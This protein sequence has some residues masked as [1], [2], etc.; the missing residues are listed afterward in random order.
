MEQTSYSGRYFRTSFGDIKSS[1]GWFGKICLLGL[2][3]LIPVFGQMTV[4]GYAYEW[5]H[6][7]A[8][9]M[10]SPMP[11]KIYGRPGS[12]MLRW[13]WFVLV[14]GIV[15]S[16]A[17]GIVMSIGGSLSS[18]G[19]ETGF[20]TATGRYMMVSPGNIALGG[21][22]WV[23]S[24]IGLVLTVFAMLMAWAGTMRMTVYD[25]LG[26]GFQ[27]GKLW[28]MVRQ[29]FGG[30]MRIFGMALLFGIIG[31]VVI[32][33]IMVIAVM[34]ILGATIAP[35]IF[36]IENGGYYTDSALIG[37]ILTLV[38][39]MLPLILVVSY[40]GLVYNAFI[41]LLVARALGYWMRQFD[42]A[43]WGTQ[44]DPLPSAPAPG[45]TPVHPEP[46]QASAGEPVTPVEPM[47]EPVDM[48][49]PPAPV[50]E[51]VEVDQAPA[52]V[53]PVEAEPSAPLALDDVVVVE[54]ALDPPVEPPADSSTAGEATVAPEGPETEAES[55][56]APESETK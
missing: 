38:A 17:P 28:A 44:N 52:P 11:R 35:L 47:G 4:Y 5:A 10:D 8:W 40:I 39:T 43:N 6:K 15:F 49:Q 42:V 9:G 25:R 20:Y 1:Q 26:A 51:P 54:E 32:G 21:L 56:D 2:I 48:Q 3:S 45:P 36:V 27:F 23:A 53:S 12:K 33:F 34:I 31:A 30:L 22:G 50:G 18:A 37:Y 24:V 46:P 19:A 14:I 41:Q 29:D 16:L 7:A 55:A 13:G